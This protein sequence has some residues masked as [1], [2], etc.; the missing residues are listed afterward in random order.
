MR[1]ANGTCTV[2]RVTIGAD[3]VPHYHKRHTEV[4]YFLS[5][6]GVIELNGRKH[7]VRPGVA[8]LIRPGT[9]HRAVSGGRSMKILNVVIPGFDPKDE[10]HD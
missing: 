10:Y 6:R 9:R 2:H 7:P 1:P 5:G 3:A 8:V 4:Y